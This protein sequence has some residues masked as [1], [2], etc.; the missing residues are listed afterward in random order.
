MKFGAVFDTDDEISFFNQWLFKRDSTLIDNIVFYLHYHVTAALFLAG[1]LIVI[2]G[3]YIMDPIDC[4]ADQAVIDVI[5]NY[6]LYHSTHTFVGNPEDILTAHP[7][8]SAKNS[9]ES[10]IKF[11]HYYLWVGL[12]LGVQATSFYIPR[13]LWKTWE[14]SRVSTMLKEK[15]TLL[16]EPS[17]EEKDSSDVLITYFRSKNHST[18]YLRLLICEL[19][20]LSN[21]VVQLT[22]TNMFLG[23]GLLNLK[24]DV[25]QLL[26]ETRPLQRSDAI[27]QMFPKVTKCV[28]YSY[29]ASGNV[30]SYDSLCVLPVNA[31]NEKLFIIIYTW[32]WLL[33]SASAIAVF[34]RIIFLWSSFRVF[35]LKFY[36][37]ETRDRSMILKKLESTLGIG[38]WQLLNQLS[39]NL[40]SWELTKFVER[41]H[42]G[43]NK[44]ESKKEEKDEG[45]STRR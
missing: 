4:I 9:L 18:Y 8:V 44:I 22:I 24:L 30:Q 10:E 13:G 21:A 2:V 17:K 6:C 7:G 28:F 1:C 23:F 32:L 12:I 14:S 19:L 36:M 41:L 16:A 33:I 5:D 3:T 38:N 39:G 20:N 40:D 31:V 37:Q 29:G 25:L 34:Y 42:A 15:E 11:H 26:R 43:L 35:M 27:D 45:E